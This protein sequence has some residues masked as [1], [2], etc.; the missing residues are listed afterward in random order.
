MRNTPQTRR[1]CEPGERLRELRRR[2]GWSLRNLAARSGIYP[3]SISRIERG[4]IRVREMTL[5]RLLRALLPDDQAADEAADLVGH[6]NV[7]PDPPFPEWAA[8]LEATR[9]GVRD[10]WK[11]YGRAPSWRQR[12]G[13][14]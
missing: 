3:G 14:W 8:K 12:R 7:V 5:R 2:R 10:G 9:D 13:G 4:R 6:P 11:R 1:P